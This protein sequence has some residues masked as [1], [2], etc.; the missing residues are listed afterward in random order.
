[1]KKKFDVKTLLFN[2]G[3]VSLTS[4]LSLQVLLAGDHSF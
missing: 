1:M 3:W 4:K 2:G